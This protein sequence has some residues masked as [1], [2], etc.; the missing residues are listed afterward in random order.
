MVEPLGKRLADPD[1]HAKVRSAMGVPINEVVGVG[2]DYF[3]DTGVFAVAVACSSTKPAKTAQT[4][5]KVKTKLVATVKELMSDAEQGELMEG[6]ALLLAAFTVDVLIGH[7]F[8][9]QSKPL[10]RLSAVAPAAVDRR[11][12]KTVDTVVRELNEPGCGEKLMEELTKIGFPAS[13]TPVDKAASRG[14]SKLEFILQW[15]SSRTG[16][17]STR[18]WPFGICMVYEG[19]RLVQIV[20][21]VSAG[22]VRYDGEESEESAALAR[23]V[24]RAVRHRGDAG[25]GGAALGVEVDLS[26]LP[27]QVTDLY[28]VLAEAEARGPPR[29]AGST[30][31]VR[32]AACGRVLTE[33]IVDSTCDSRAAVMC[34]LSKDP[35]HKKWVVHGLGLKS[36]GSATQ[37]GPIRETIAAR[38]AGYLRWE[39]R[40]AIVT[41][42]TLHKLDRLKRGS[43]SKFASLLWGVS[44][45]PASSRCCALGCSRPPGARV[46]LE[47]SS[48][49]DK[50]L[51]PFWERLGC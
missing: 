5:E 22:G 3:S 17:G 49:L 31:A 48:V 50:L 8:L 40:A 34:S 36:R 2:T 4:I 41:V 7:R 38:Q 21:V 28:F 42:R 51:A 43:Q 14:L 37:Y 29:L 10:K 35:D 45:P 16:S 33:Y 30:V 44:C 15:G 9:V 27:L 20:D 24:S 46:A 25:G 13:V 23:A 26:A 6:P 19:G 18:D 12:L 32:D 47:S 1:L 11:R 39:R